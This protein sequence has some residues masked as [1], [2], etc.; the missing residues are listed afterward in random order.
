MCR[1]SLGGD[2]V[3]QTDPKLSISSVIMA[4]VN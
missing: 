3:A 1:G 4:D 2:C